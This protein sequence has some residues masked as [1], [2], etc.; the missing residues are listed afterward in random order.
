MTVDI[1]ITSAEWKKDNYTFNVRCIMISGTLIKGGKYIHLKSGDV[2][3]FLG[4]LSSSVRW[5]FE[6]CGFRKLLLF[7][8]FGHEGPLYSFQHSNQMYSKQNLQFTDT[9][10]TEKSYLTQTFLVKFTFMTLLSLYKSQWSDH[11]I[12][13]KW[14]ERDAKKWKER[15][16]KN[17]VSV[18]WVCEYF[19]ISFV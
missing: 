12:K 13:L 10:K 15:D 8:Y 19:E 6:L 1:K 2:V 14:K 3:I 11:I 9:C 16:A 4:L 18:D 7:L 5:T 17:I